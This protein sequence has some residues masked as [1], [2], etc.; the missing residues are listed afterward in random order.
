MSTSARPL[1]VRLAASSDEQLEALLRTRGARPDAIWNDFFDAAEWL[2]E[3]S[4]VERAIIA[5]TQQEARDLQRATSGADAGASS[6]ALTDLAL[7]DDDGRVPPAVAAVVSTRAEVADTPTDAPPAASEAE[8]ARAAERAFATVGAVAD[9]LLAARRTPLALVASGALTAGE[10]RRL[11]E[12]GIDS[13]S[14]EDLRALAL[15]ASLAEADERTLLTAPTA[16]AWLAAPFATR[17]AALV[18][19]FRDGA[20]RG[21]R[22]GN[23]WTVPSSWA[24]AHPWDASWPAQADRLRRTAVLLGLATPSDSEPPWG[25]AAREGAP[26]DAA[27]LSALLPSEVDR[28]FLQNDL[29]AI[30][31]GPLLPTLDNRLRAMTEHDSAQASSYR[32]TAESV[33]R[34]LVEGES[35]ESLTAFLSELSLTGLPQPLTYLLAQTAARHGLVRVASYDGGGTRVTSTDSGLLAAIEVDRGLRPLGLLREDDSLVTRVGAETVA[36]ALTDS[37]Y[38]A[39]LVDATGTPIAATRR[40]RREQPPP[41]LPSYGPLI[42]RLRE[43]H[44]VDSDAAWLDRELDAAVRARAVLEVEVAM[45]DGSRRALVLEASGLGGGRLRGRD[46]AADVERTLPVRSIRSV[47]VVTD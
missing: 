17:W 4:A 14:A 47:R 29:T 11:A 8:T 21:I 44:E 19:A 16:E 15:T 24:D 40:H 12:S 31:P 32:F 30:A 45:P 43:H 39:T 36:W 3:P 18:E 46:R 41:E 35:V 26:A 33:S 28:V 25:T 23:G 9:L 10:R 38:P 2:L 5:L 42:A 37:R 13:E 1:A 7:L 27:P 22:S 20:P 34:A 6:E